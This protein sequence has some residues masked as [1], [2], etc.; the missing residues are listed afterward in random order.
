MLHDFAGASPDASRAA[1]VAA[2][3]D[4]CG[5]VELGQDSSVWYGAVLR[6]DVASITIGAM[7]NI[8]DGCVVHVD[9]GRPCVLGEG[10]S[11]GHRAVVHACDIGSYSLIGM[12]AIVLDGAKIGEQ[13]IV[14]AGSLVT[15]NK[16]FPPGSMILGSPAKVVRELTLGYLE[17]KT[18]EEMADAG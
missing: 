14:G 3:A 16:S 12:G 8:Q 7:T 17:V 10:V 13:C 2:S 5:S 9:S 15:Q 11:V 4:V 1:F 18:I 6:G